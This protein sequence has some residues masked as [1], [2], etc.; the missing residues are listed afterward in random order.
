MKKIISVLTALTIIISLCGNVTMATDYNNHWAKNDIITLLNSNI[1]SGDEMGNINP[2]NM[3]TRAEFVK[4]INRTFNYNILLGVNFKDV[5]SDKWYYNDFLI[6]KNEGYITGDNFG[7]ANPEDLITRAEVSVIY[8]RILGLPMNYNVSSFSDASTIPSWATGYIG[9]LCKEGL[10]S[11]Y[12]DNTFRADKSMTRGEAFSLTSRIYKG[13][14]LKV[15]DPGYIYNPPSGGNGGSSGGNGGSSDSDTLESPVVRN[16]SEETIKI[17]KVDDASTYVVK[18]KCEELEK[19]YELKEIDFC[20]LDNDII[21]IPLKS[22]ISDFYSSVVVGEFD[23]EISIK[24][25]GTSSNEDS[26]Y[27]FVNKSQIS[28][29]SLTAPKAEWGIKTFDGV[30]KVFVKWTE[31]ENTKEHIV[32]LYVNNVE[33]SI[34]VDQTNNMATFSPELI[35][36]YDGVVSIL[37]KSKTS[38]LKSPKI[39][40]VYPT[41]DKMPGKGT[42]EDPYIIRSVEEFENISDYSAVYNIVCDLDLRESNVLGSSDNPFTGKIIGRK[43]Y[44]DNEKVTILLSKKEGTYNAFIGYLKGTIKNIITDGYVKGDSYIA[45]IAGHNDGEIINCVNKATI[46]SIGHYMGGITS[47]NTGLIE[48]CANIG[49][50]KGDADN[51]VYGGGIAGYSSGKIRKCYNSGDMLTKGPFGGIVGTAAG[52]NCEITDCFNTGYLDHITGGGVS[53]IANN[54]TATNIIIKNNYNVGGIREGTNYSYN[55]YSPLG[56]TTK[57]SDISQNYFCSSLTKLDRDGG[58]GSKNLELS[59]LENLD[60]F[61]GFSKDVWEINSLSGY[62]YPQLKGNPYMSNIMKLVAPSGITVENKTVKFITDDREK[63][64]TVSVYKDGKVQYENTHTEEE[65][66]LAAIFVYN[67]EYDIKIKSI[68]ESE[69]YLT[70]SDETVY[71]YNFNEGKEPLKNITGFDMTYTDGDKYTVTWNSD[72]E[73]YYNITVSDNY[74]TYISENNIAGNTFDV[75]I[76]GEFKGNG[77]FKFAVTGYNTEDKDISYGDFLIDTRFGNGEGSYE[78][79]FEIWNLRHL[80]N[81]EL[82]NTMNF[83]QKK[84]ITEP[85]TTPISEFKGTYKGDGNHKKIVLDINGESYLGLFGKLTGGTVERIITTGSIEGNSYIGG[86]AGESKGTI[87]Y[88]INKAEI[89]GLIVS[90]QNMGGIAGVNNGIIDSCGNEGEIHSADSVVPGKYFQHIGGIAGNNQNKIVKSYNIGSITAGRYMGGI[91]G[92]STGG[93]SGS[94]EISDCYNAGALN[95]TDYGLGGIVHTMGSSDTTSLI[96]EN[97]YNIGKI[98][99]IGTGGASSYNFNVYQRY[100]IGESGTAKV[101]NNYFCSELTEWIDIKPVTE[102]TGTI[103]TPV[104]IIISDL[105]DLNKFEGF[106]SDIWEVD[107]TSDYKYPKHKWMKDV[108]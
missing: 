63:N 102:G 40:Y 17:N 104:E 34:D 72:S 47:N 66:D 108:K 64:H 89:K 93:N 31:D 19:E 39:K 43:D 101:L 106:S 48:N 15:D 103:K 4:V 3:I 10:L 21:S 91:A 59:D 29:P 9:A 30:E 86:I 76:G 73:S 50:I 74:G 2:D 96:L 75:I 37:A 24:S 95:H 46:H 98:T 5:T 20:E 70:D 87:K 65:I 69:G 56:S 53:G 12:S 77:Q 18:I 62:K 78:K 41:L 54:V 42:D 67:G 92:V 83:I 61:E 45:G 79:P 82:A 35:K 80:K 23:M 7:N 16:Y 57:T 28:L 52:A 8:S 25:K 81:V 71:K 84:D 107:E 90:S 11:G 33:K 88:C 22:I 100:E 60:K 6:A 58:E 99:D 97:N 105:G 68:A 51:Y 14:D 13:Q 44:K 26:S 1:I 27:S 55:I 94:Y 85:L 32:K 38:D 36:E 49:Q